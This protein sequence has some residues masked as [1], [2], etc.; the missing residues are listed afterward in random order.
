MAA[1]YNFEAIKEVFK[2]IHREGQLIDENVLSAELGKYSLN[3]EQNAQVREF[4]ESLELTDEE[5]DSIISWYE[6][7]GPT[8]LDDKDAELLEEDDID[9]DENIDYGEDL[10][11]EDIDVLSS[12]EN[13]LDLQDLQA[14]Y[15]DSLSDRVSD[16]VKMY[17]KE[18]GQVPLLKADEEREIA[19]VAREGDETINRKIAELK[20]AKGDHSAEI[21]E[22]EEYNGELIKRAKDKMITANLRLVVALAKKYTNRG[23]LFLD[24]I[25]EGN[26][27]LVKAVDKFDY[28]KGFKFSTYATWWIRQAITRAIADQARTIRIPVHMVETINKMTKVQRQLVQELGREPSAEEISEVIAS[29]IA[30]CIEAILPF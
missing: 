30:T 27:G 25:Q 28:E 5:L 18:I 29:R 16:P 26:V 1:K 21:S 7:L 10:E 4:L 23:L 12:D 22:L 8:E 11:D 24:L 2:N 20:K 15:A 17:L 13:D 6:N 9:I 19:K 3:N 14:N